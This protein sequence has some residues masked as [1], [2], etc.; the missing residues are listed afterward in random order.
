[1]LWKEHC[2]TKSE[3]LSI[4]SNIEQFELKLHQLPGEP[5]SLLWNQGINLRLLL[6]SYESFFSHPY[7]LF[8]VHLFWHLQICCTLAVGFFERL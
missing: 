6:P 3:L 7:P 8:I 5:V 4:L 2:L 1:M